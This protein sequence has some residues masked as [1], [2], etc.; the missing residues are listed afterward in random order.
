[1][2]TV[3]DIPGSHEAAI[4]GRVIRPDQGDLPDEQ[5]RALLR[6]RFEQHDLDRLHDLL[7]KNRDD[8]LMP[9]E[10]EELEGY[11]RVSALLDLMHARARYSLRKP[12]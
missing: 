4:L 11:L 3:Q 12:D 9:A 10:K 8:E 5:A 2:A 1:M 7:V 6:M